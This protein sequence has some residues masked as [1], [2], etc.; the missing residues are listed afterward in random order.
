MVAG[1]VPVLVPVAAAPPVIITPQT[2]VSI[3]ISAASISLLCPL[4]PV[5]AVARRTVVVLVMVARRRPPVLVVTVSVVVDTGDGG[6]GGLVAA[7]SSVV[8]TEVG[9]AWTAIID[10]RCGLV[11]RPGDTK[12]HANPVSIQFHS[13]HSPT[14]LLRFCD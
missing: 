8:E 10:S 3:I 7:M 5:V 9:P 13:I 11:G 14:C 1:S 6:L 2:L 4:S 12:I